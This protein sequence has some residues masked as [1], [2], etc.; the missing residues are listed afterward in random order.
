MIVDLSSPLHH[1]VNDSIPQE[2]TSLSYAKVDDAVDIIL[3]LGPGT[4][5]VKIDLQSAYRVVPIHPDDH[6]LLGIQWEGLIVPY[7]LAYN[8]PQRYSRQWLT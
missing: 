5:L 3:Q 7:L 6:H 8:Q 4:E 2:L 1:S